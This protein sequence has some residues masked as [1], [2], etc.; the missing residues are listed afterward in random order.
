MQTE[1]EQLVSSRTVVAACASAK[2][3]LP[4]N[5]PVGPRVGL[6]RVVPPSLWCTHVFTSDLVTHHYSW[7]GLLS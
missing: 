3:S 7:P 1:Q 4:G 2:T 5:R 6:E